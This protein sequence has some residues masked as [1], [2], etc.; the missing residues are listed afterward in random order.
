MEWVAVVIMCCRFAVGSDVVDTGLYM[1]VKMLENMIF[2]YRCSNLHLHSRC[3]EKCS[4]PLCCCSFLFLC[5][6]ASN[7]RGP[8]VL[9]FRNVPKMSLFWYFAWCMMSMSYKAKQEF[10]EIQKCDNFPANTECSPNV[11]AWFPFGIRLFF[12]EPNDNFRGTFYKPKFNFLLCKAN[13]P[14]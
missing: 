12:W 1:E 3:E 4:G 13:F 9:G 11:P 6:S 7:A 10:S 2:R 5:L 14:G 8:M